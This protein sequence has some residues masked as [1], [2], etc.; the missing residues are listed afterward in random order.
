MLHKP[1]YKITFAPPPS[2]GG[3]GGL[4]GGGSSVIDTATDPQAS[5]VVSLTVHLDMQPAADSFTLVMGQVGSFAPAF[6]GEV[7][8]ELGDTGDNTLTQVIK[9]TITDMTPGIKT[10]RVI[11]HNAAWSLLRQ[12]ADETIESKN[13]G[14]IVR[15]LAGRAGVTV[16]EAESG[17]SLPAYVIDGRRNAYHHM[18]YLA[19]LCGFD[20]YITSDDQLVFKRFTQGATRHTFKYA[21][22]VLDLAVQSVKAPFSKISAWGESPGGSQSQQDWA[23]LTKDF[24]ALSHTAGSDDTTLL[25][26]NAALRSGASTQ[27]AAD[28]RLARI[29]RR[30]LRGRLVVAGY[31]AV[32]LGDSV[33]LTEMPDSALNQTY[34]VRAITHHVSKRH[35]FTTVIGFQQMP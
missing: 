3:L 35:G 27:A 25:L 33:E 22:H 7:T 10:R 23:W 31:P 34:Q 28:A 12:Y 8:I 15:D 1:A 6:G 19:E 26:E 32:K 21:Q 18:Q 16:A 5:T 9:G 13:A 17:I 24:S 20:L 4:V 30:T 11:G 29:E 14:Q 2:S